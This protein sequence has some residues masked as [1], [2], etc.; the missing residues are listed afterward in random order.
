VIRKAQ[1]E[2]ARLR[3][4]TDSMVTQE[5]LAQ[6]LGCSR[7]AVSKKAIREGWTKASSPALE[8]ARSLDCSKPIA[9]SQFGK[10]SPE[11]IAEIINVFA[12]TGNK[13]LACRRVGISPDTL[14]RWAKAEPELA[15]AIQAYR[16]QHLIDQ[17]RKIA[18]AT[19]WKAAREILA[20]APETA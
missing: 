16:S 13:S 1:W 14:A 12:L 19:D 2:S 6:E 18:N 10:R 8:V 7:Q 15:V 5:A 17:Y 11:N 9:G 4:E 20:R 3:Y